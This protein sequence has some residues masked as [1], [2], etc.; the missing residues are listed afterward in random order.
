MDV[1]L[2]DDKCIVCNKM[3]AFIVRNGGNDKFRFLSLFSDQGKI[4]LKKGGL[5]ENYN[6]SVVFVKHNK[7][8]L[9]SSAVLQVVK[10]LNG[11][12]PLLYGLIIIP[13]PIRD[14]VYALIAKHR[15]NMKI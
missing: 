2:I 8:Y 13:K 3:V 12:F 15:H 5:P 4:I 11:L 14:W 6:K 10:K 1:L 7:I 9:K